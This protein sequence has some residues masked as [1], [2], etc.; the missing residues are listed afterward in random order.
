VA[1]FVGDAILDL[2]A[3]SVVMARHPKDDVRILN[4]MAED[5]LRNKTLWRRAKAGAIPQLALCR[6][7]EKAERLPALRKQLVA[8]KVQADLMEAMIGVVCQAQIERQAEPP[9]PNPFAR[10]LDAAFAF[11]NT[12]VF[13]VPMVVDGG[14]VADLLM[15]TQS[16]WFVRSEAMPA[17]GRDRAQDISAALSLEFKRRKDLLIE[18]SVWRGAKQDGLVFQRLEFLGDAFLQCMWLQTFDQNPAPKPARGA[19]SLQPTAPV[20]AAHM[21]ACGVWQVWCL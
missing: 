13:E 11:C 4:P 19:I 16:E 2:H 17:A 12:F 18:C 9:M 8:P 20:R 3:K 14:S 6:P 15:M 1:E 5:L 7:F 21:P 10:G